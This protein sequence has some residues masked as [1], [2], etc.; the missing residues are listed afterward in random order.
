M[1]LVMSKTETAVGT[2][3][4]RKIIKSQY[5]ASLAMLR[6]TIERCPE[7]L[8]MSTASTNAFW[9]IAYHAVFFAHL[10]MFPNAQSDR[11]IPK[12][13]CL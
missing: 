1:M 10:Y 5:H 12:V 4:I 8:W 11:R 2:D 13:R 3:E 9:Q 6:E 7:E